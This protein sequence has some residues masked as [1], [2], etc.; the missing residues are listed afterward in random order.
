MFRYSHERE[1]AMN[2]LASGEGDVVGMSSVR[3]PPAFSAV[4]PPQFEN[5]DFDLAYPPGIEYHYWNLARNHIIEHQLN[6]ITSSGIRILE[7]GCGKG[8]VVDYLRRKG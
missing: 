1:V 5:D 8:I 2:V 6:A 4:G 3:E 7:I